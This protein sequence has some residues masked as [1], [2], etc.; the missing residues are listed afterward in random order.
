MTTRQKLILLGFLTLIVIVVLLLLKPMP[1]DP[2]YHHFA[3]SRLLW[4][5]PNFANVVS[6]FLFLVVGVKGLLLLRRSSAAVGMMWIYGV[7][8]LGIFLIGCGSAYYHWRPDNERLIYD[9]LP[10]TLVFMG[11]LSA[12]IGEM[13]DYRAGFYLLVPL[14]VLGIFSVLWWHYTESIGRG[15][16]RLY[17]LVQFYSV[18]LISLI[19][20]LF[21]GQVGNNGAGQLRWVVVWYI[22]AKLCEKFDKQIF[23]ALGFISGHSIKHMAAAV[24]TW[25]LA[26]MF[27]MKYPK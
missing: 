27:R 26:K 3:D 20:V 6:N 13:I 18:I 10:M 12:T 7:I 14:L 17:G 19:L 16:L 4:G 24:A 23:S 25:Y 11:L 2:T 21:S 22:I 5:I 1:Q 9:R 15:D 8:F